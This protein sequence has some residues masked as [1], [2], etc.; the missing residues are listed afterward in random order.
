[1]YLSENKNRYLHVNSMLELEAY[2]LI[3]TGYEKSYSDFSPFI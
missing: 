3:E 2:R 1:M